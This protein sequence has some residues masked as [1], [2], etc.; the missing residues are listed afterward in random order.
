M[1]QSI[2][3]IRR[4]GLLR[5]DLLVRAFTSLGAFQMKVRSMISA[6]FFLACVSSARPAEFTNSRLND[7][8]LNCDTCHGVGGHSPTPDQVPSLAGKNEKYLFAQFKAFRDGKRKHETMIF[9]SN[10]MSE[11]EMREIAL[12][13]SRGGK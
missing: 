1:V 9:I 13:Y 7:L 4:L 5:A 3:R 12:Y 11:G 6:C 2:R 10:S 8:K